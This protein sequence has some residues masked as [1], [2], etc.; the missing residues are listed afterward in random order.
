MCDRKESR[1]SKH[2][3]F[4]IRSDKILFANLLSINDFTTK[5]WETNK[6]LKYYWHD[7]IELSLD[8]I[9]KVE[10]SD[11]SYKIHFASKCFFVSFA[12]YT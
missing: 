4:S 11:K 6:L 7:I 2:D 12:E 8:S 9:L 1:S 5:E 3:L 10:I